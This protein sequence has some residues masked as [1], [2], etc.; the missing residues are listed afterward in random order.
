VVAQGFSDKNGSGGAENKMSETPS[1][2]TAI[3]LDV[4]HFLWDML[5]G[6][7]MSKT[8]AAQVELE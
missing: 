3:R 1:H 6:V 2:S 7:S 4:T 5:S 8:K